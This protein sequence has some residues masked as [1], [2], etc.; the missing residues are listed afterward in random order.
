MLPV[1]GKGVRSDGVPTFYGTSG[2]T[3][4]WLVT[5]VATTDF[6]LFGYDQ[7]VMSGIISAE[8]FVTAFPEVEGVS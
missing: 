5:A 8:A 6:L 1:I 2:R 7:G 4:Q 3:L